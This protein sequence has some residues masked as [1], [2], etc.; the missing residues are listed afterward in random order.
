MGLLDLAKNLFRGGGKTV[1]SFALGAGNLEIPTFLRAGGSRISPEVPISKAVNI[2]RS[3]IP[4]PVPQSMMDSLHSKAIPTNNLIDEVAVTEGPLRAALKKQPTPTKALSNKGMLFQF[5][6]GALEGFNS[7]GTYDSMMAA[8]IGGLAGGFASFGTSVLF[9]EN[10]QYNGTVKPIVKGVITG[11]A[12]G[13]LHG[14]AKSVLT[15]AFPQNP[16]ISEFFGITD[17]L[18]NSTLYK[19]ALGAAVFGS[20]GSFTLTRPVNRQSG[21]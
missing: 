10:A 4:G 8:G 14:G 11:A 19:G 3:K 7:T 20:T 16:K 17:K 21:V 5:G 13:A 15:R 12:I 9:P 2:T 18:T 6:A 1:E